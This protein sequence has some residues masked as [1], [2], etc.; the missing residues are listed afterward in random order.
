M[1]VLGGVTGFFDT[2][3]QKNRIPLIFSI[4]LLFLSA[5]PRNVLREPRE[6]IRIESDRDF[7][8]LL[9]VFASR[10]NTPHH[11]SKPDE[12]IRF[13][14]CLFDRTL[15]YESLALSSG[16]GHPPLGIITR[17]WDT[18]WGT[19]SPVPPNTFDWTCFTKYFLVF[20]G[21][22]GRYALRSR[23]TLDLFVIVFDS[24]TPHFFAF[25][26]RRK[27]KSFLTCCD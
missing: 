1:S 8:R 3:N 18:S 27:K 20:C 5:S 17:N 26:S 2:V 13:R 24:P 9:T 19:A 21:G 16:N 22:N 14:Q 4:L 12:D 10:S 11:L 25:F 23:I 7:E 15:T 6:V